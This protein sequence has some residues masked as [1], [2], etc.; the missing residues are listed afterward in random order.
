ML[1]GQN[2]YAATS[3]LFNLATFIAIYALILL[4][5]IVV[6]M[7]SSAYDDPS[8]RGKLVVTGHSEP[9]YLSGSQKALNVF[10]RFKYATLLEFFLCAMINLKAVCTHLN[11]F[12]MH[13]CDCWFVVFLGDRHKCAV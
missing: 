4:A 1:M 13:L 6:K 2:G 12:N 3:I 11:L 5:N 9:R 8:R 7:M 10:I